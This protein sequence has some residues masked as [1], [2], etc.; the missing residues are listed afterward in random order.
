MN[1]IKRIGKKG[2]RYILQKTFEGKQRQISLGIFR[3]KRDAETKAAIFMSTATKNGLQTAINEL[4]GKTV[5][6][7]GD[8]VTFRVMKER[9]REYCQFC[10][11]P[12]NG[13]K[14]PPREGTIK[15]YLE[16]LNRTMDKL[17]VSETSKIEKV[18]LRKM[19]LPENPT[20]SQERGFETTI[21][22]ARSIFKKDALDWYN[23][24]ERNWNIQNP[25]Q[26]YKI[27]SPAIEK[28]EP[29]PEETQDTL[30]DDCRKELPPQE[31]MI[32]L[33]A[34]HTGMRRSEIE[35]CSV[36]WWV[37]HK[38]KVQ[39][40]VRTSSRGKTKSGKTRS[41]PFSLTIYKELLELREKAGATDNFFVPVTRRKKKPSKDSKEPA[42]FSESGKGRLY[43][44]FATA[45]KWLREKGI[46]CTFPVHSLRKMAG[47]NIAND[48]GLLE[49]QETLGHKDP[50][51][52]SDYYA[53]SAGRNTIGENPESK[54]ENPIQAT[55]DLMGITLEEALKR[56]AT[57][58]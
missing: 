12:Q 21:R 11:D 40:T 13:Q 56:L 57:P 31:V 43:R 23:A 17:E 50:K 28:Y 32:C 24:P 44:K 51:V 34:A 46:N 8:A 15:G 7:R 42:K 1:L 30:L 49:A 37:E 47:S 41:F 6:K 26:G 52:T 27:N 55:A 35:A 54:K 18:N 9:Y 14:F 4:A 20:E 16:A 45:N 10:K 19:M 48:Y 53:S 22:N 29:L 5:F 3:T 36:D 39:L 25:F 38:D 33:L 2:N 58:S